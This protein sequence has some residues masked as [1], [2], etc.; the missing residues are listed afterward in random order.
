MEVEI[1]R[2]TEHPLLDVGRFAAASTRGDLSP[3]RCL[4]RARACVRKGHD[5][6]LEA[7]T[8]AAHVSGVSRA[9][10]MQLVRHRSLSFCMESQRYTTL[11]ASGEWLVVPPSVEAAGAGAAFREA[12]EAQAALYR[13]LLDGGV[14]PEDARFCLPEA[15]ATALNVA[16]DARALWSFLSQRLDPH[17][18]WEVRAAAEA[19]RDRLAALSDEWAELLALLAERGA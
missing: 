14:P 4:A 16:G 17:A 10:A 8:F 3:E 11:D 13:R 6:V 19:L 2:A 12:A 5:S 18:Q 7:A 1:V 9:C 15:S